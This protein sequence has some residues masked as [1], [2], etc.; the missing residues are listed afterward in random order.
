MS[1]QS[2]FESA[3]ISF[4]DNEVAGGIGVRLAEPDR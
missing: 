4:L 2:A 1:I 3:G